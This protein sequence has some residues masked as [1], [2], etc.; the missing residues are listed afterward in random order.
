MSVITKNVLEHVLGWLFMIATMIA[1]HLYYVWAE[2]EPMD[3]TPMVDGLGL[4]LNWF[5]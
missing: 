2:L 5:S 4:L 3:A 1:V